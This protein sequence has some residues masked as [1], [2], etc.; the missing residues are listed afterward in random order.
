MIYRQCKSF[1]KIY[2]DDRSNTNPNPARKRS[3]VDIVYVLV[4]GDGMLWNHDLWNGWS[5]L[6]LTN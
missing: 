2:R 1:S 6:R 3:D 5:H 4:L